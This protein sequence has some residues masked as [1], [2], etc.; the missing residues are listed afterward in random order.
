MLKIFVKTPGAAEVVTHTFHFNSPTDP[1]SE[2]NIIK[3]GLSNLIAAAKVG[4]PSIP[5]SNG[6]AGVAGSM[7]MAS[8]AVARP[9]SQSEAFYDD[10]FLKSSIELQQSLMRKDPVLQKIYEETRLSKLDSVSNT[11]FNT[12]FWS[13]RTNLLRA[14]AVEV[15][16]RKG[17]YNVLSTV[18]TRTEDG[19][20]KLK[21]SKEQIALLFRQ[22]PLVKRVY[23]ENV[24]TR[25][26]EQTF[27]SR[28]FL[29]RLNKKLKGERIVESDAKDA[30]LDKYLEAA[31]SDLFNST[32]LSSHVPNTIDLEANEENQGGAK[33]GNRQDFTM[34]P[35]SSTK[36]PIIRTLNSISNKIM[37]HVAVSD[38]NPADPIG[39]DESTYNELILRDLQGDPEEARI[40]LKVNEQSRFLSGDKAK[41][42]A[43][44][45][46]YRDQ[47]PHQLLTS[48]RHDVSLES[49][50]QDSAGGLNIK[51]AIGVDEDSD[52]DDDEPKVPRV[53]SRSGLLAAQKQVWD[54]I[55]S[56]KNLTGGGEDDREGLS[57]TTF[58]K[59]VLANATTTV[60]LSQFWN[61]FLSGNAERAGELA[62]T[63]ESLDRSLDRINALAADAEVEREQE[64]QRQ[65]QYVRKM[66]AESGKKL[67]FKKEK[68]KGGQRVVLSM[69]EPTIGAL[70]KASDKYRE[71]L[72]ME[73]IDT[74]A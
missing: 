14:H 10:A 68:I 31:D 43:E 2:A 1:R 29:S 37:A 19:A 58:E 8:A 21:I 23:D 9:T 6:N 28:F 65:M 57:Q 27:W 44:E 17:E 45:L 66:Y 60:F 61:A 34:R 11:Q 16:Q 67:V 52:S 13:S 36:A 26:D 69:L 7:A 46:A 12:Q 50:G 22:H 56:Q 54:G 71:A 18:K 25:Y 15:S 38:V 24:P 72:T 47:D 3:E 32:F 4:D 70:R 30:I 42:S 5:K 73:G 59:I 51:N 48:L 62:K 33:S 20:L 40:L 53:G 39:M 35:A 41:P 49:M 55:V 74:T 64:V 63:V